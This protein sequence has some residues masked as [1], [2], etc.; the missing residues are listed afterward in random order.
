MQEG[1]Q[2]KLIEILPGS[3]TAT[4]PQSARRS[5]LICALVAT[6]S[7]LA[8]LALLSRAHATSDFFHYWSASRTLLAG[9]DP[10]TVIPEGPGNPGA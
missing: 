9:G 10:Y 4:Y 1:W 3:W 2:V 5:L 7:A 6:V 8:T